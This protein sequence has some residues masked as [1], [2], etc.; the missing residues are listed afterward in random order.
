M[1]ISKLICYFS[2]HPAAF[3]FKAST[4]PDNTS[5]NFANRKV[6]QFLSSFQTVLGAAAHATLDTKQL[7]SLL[8]VALV[9][10]L[11]S[12]PEAEGDVIPVSEVCELLLRICG[13]LDKAVSKQVGNSACILAHLFNSVS[14]QCE[15][16]W[17]SQFPSL[18]SL[19]E[20][21]PPSEACLYAHINWSL[22][23]A[24]SVGLSQS[25]PPKRGGKTRPWTRFQFTVQK[26]PMSGSVPGTS[27][28]SLPK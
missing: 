26:R 8:Q 6:D 15:E 14:R 7:I 22:A 1:S 10:T 9:D 2:S 3:G 17:V 20:V 11:S 5:L 18:H 27:G 13:I 12:L 21:I 23:Q 28:A 4:P 25:F 24:H 16:V 19:K